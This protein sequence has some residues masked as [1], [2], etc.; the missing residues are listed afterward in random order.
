MAL[1]DF[2]HELRFSHLR[3]IDPL[4]VEKTSSQRFLGR[5]LL[6]FVF[7]VKRKQNKHDADSEKIGFFHVHI[8]RNVGLFGIG[9]MIIQVYM[10]II[11]YD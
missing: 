10:N 11:E 6:L 7:A 3:S 5:F 9:D 2:P 4:A 8:C 1:W